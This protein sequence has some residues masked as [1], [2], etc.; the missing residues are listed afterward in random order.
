[1][2]CYLQLYSARHTAIDESLRI[3]AESGYS[4]VEAFRDNFVDGDVFKASLKKYGLSVPSIHINLDRLRTDMKA[5]ISLAREFDCQHIVCPYLEE[6]ER[7]LDTAAW[8]TLAHELVVIESQLTDAGCTFAWHNHDFEFFALPDG[9][10]PIEHL[11][12]T[13]GS[14]QWEIDVAW[15]VRAAVDPAPWIKRY[16][17]RLSAVHLKDI[18]PAGNCL[19]EDGWADLGEGIVAWESLMPS[20]LESPAELFITEHDNPA[21]LQR[22][23][24]RSIR[25][26]NALSAHK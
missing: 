7:P 26:F 11:L 17:S 14:M 25:A 21:D 4:G 6:Q 3:A 8:Q 23:A 1:M 19:D 10:M 9:S 18:A 15:I 24:T 2:N 13:A 20:L 16:Q 22:F 12:K 5:C